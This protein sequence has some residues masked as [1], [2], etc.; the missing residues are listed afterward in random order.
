[1]GNIVQG[2]DREANIAR[3]EA[4]FYICRETMPACNISCSARA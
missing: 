3:G 4:E 2:R 1:M